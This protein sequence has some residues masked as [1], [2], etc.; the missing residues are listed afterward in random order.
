M[1]KTAVIFALAT[2]GIAVL[3]LAGLEWGRRV[4]SPEERQ[5]APVSQAEPGS[6]SGPLVTLGSGERVEVKKVRLA[7]GSFDLLTGLTARE[8][9]AIGANSGG[10][11]FPLLFLLTCIW[12][13]LALRD[14]ENHP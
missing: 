3:F 5:L 11:L 14:P 7:F 10:S 8:L 13:A 9:E 6:E 4:Y 1:R 12:L 2:L